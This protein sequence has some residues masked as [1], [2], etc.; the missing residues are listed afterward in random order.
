MIPIRFRIE[1][2]FLN[3][4]EAEAARQVL[5]RYSSVELDVVEG[6]FSCKKFIIEADER[7]VLKDLEEKLEKN[8]VHLSSLWSA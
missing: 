5:D 2:R 6:E 4:R 8:G 7:E 1:T 3:E